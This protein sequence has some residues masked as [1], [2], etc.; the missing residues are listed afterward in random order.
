M[1]GLD[2]LLAPMLALL[3]GRSSLPA[4]LCAAAVRSDV[5]AGTCPMAAEMRSDRLDDADR[6][7]LAAVAARTRSADGAIVPVSCEQ[8]R[9]SLARAGIR[10]QT[11]VILL[12]LVTRGWFEPTPPT[13]VLLGRKKVRAR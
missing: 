4:D 9:A 12:A 7:V 3:E 5:E 2:E 8:I 10:T 1:D 6:W 11:P 13:S